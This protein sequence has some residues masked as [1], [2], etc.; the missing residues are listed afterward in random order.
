[1]FKAY[2]NLILESTT[3]SKIF[4]KIRESYIFCTVVGHRCHTV[5]CAFLIWP[6]LNCQ[7]AP[8]IANHALADDSDRD[9]NEYIVAKDANEYDDHEADAAADDK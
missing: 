6:P 2:E 3:F 5:L 8:D 9:D 4:W 1:M 7:R